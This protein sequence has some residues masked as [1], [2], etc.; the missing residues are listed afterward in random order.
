MAHARTVVIAGPRRELR[1]YA[2]RDTALEVLSLP[3]EIERT[4]A[5]PARVRRLR[6]RLDHAR[7]TLAS[8]HR[9]ERVLRQRLS[10][11]DE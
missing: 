1:G 10:S 5:D 2:G 6:R 9:V 3:D 4:E 7:P 8:R 11:R